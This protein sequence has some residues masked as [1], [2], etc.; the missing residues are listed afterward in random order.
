MAIT[1]L[2]S[3]EFAKD[4]AQQAVNYVPEDLNSDQKNYVAKKVYEFSTIAGNHLIEHYNSQLDDEQAKIIVQFIGEWT[5][6]KSIDIIRANIP[7]DHWAEILQQ[8][9]FAALQTA[10]QAFLEKQDQSKIAAKIETQVNIAYEACIKNLANAG[11]LPEDKVNV[12]M[13]QSNVDKMAK[14]N[15]VNILEDEE[16]IMKYATFAILLKNLPKEKADSLI[17][18]FSDPEK[19]YINS[20]LNI[21]GLEQKVD[22]SLVNQYLKDIKK[23]LAG[24]TKPK[25][26]KIIADIKALRN[27]YDDQD[28]FNTLITERS[29]V[30][31]FLET[32]L[33]ESTSKAIKIGFSPY[34]AKLLYSY[35]KS[36]LAPQG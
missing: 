17:S 9:A 8:I 3:Q 4:L 15:S 33:F 22:P 11:V 36:K 20:Y 19:Q 1:G 2:N 14:E 29:L 23:N 28:I 18:N 30:L 31:D 26:S 12:A 6:H 32:C 25:I 7:Q 10:V 34:I 21:E 27:N 24:I 35:V 13:S 16:K 5:F